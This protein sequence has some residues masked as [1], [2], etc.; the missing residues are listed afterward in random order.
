[1]ARCYGVVCPS[2][3]PTTHRDPLHTDARRAGH[4][5][6]HGSQH[7]ARRLVEGAQ[8]RVVPL[9]SP[10]ISPDGNPPLR[11]P[12]P[13]S[14][15]SLF[16]D[17]ATISGSIGGRGRRGE[18]RAHNAS[19]AGISFTIVEDGS[20]Y[21]L[22]LEA[23]DKDLDVT[24]RNGENRVCLGTDLA[25]TQVAYVPDEDAFALCNIRAILDGTDTSQA[26]F[27]YEMMRG[28]CARATAQSS[29]P[30]A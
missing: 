17:Q 6:R 4:A 2:P 9:P 18:I 22:D 30:Q 8:C 19:I 25:A 5:G 26:W 23:V 13:V 11:A 27:S 24:Y 16:V 21:L 10:E 1:M 15:L 3:S 20:F 14:T 29:R 7:Q 12:Q 28:K